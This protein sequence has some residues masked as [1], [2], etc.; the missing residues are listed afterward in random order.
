M[1]KV[2]RLWNPRLEQNR[3]TW[4]C[5]ASEART[6]AAELK[7]K[8]ERAEQRR[9]GPQACPL[10]PAEYFR[11]SYGAWHVKHMRAERKAQRQRRTHEEELLD[12]QPL[13][14]YTWRTQQS[15]RPRGA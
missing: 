3:Q 15:A 6:G 13:D 14:V 1:K 5:D 9:H 2:W 11:E 8:L 10:A 12:V 7:E 4:Q